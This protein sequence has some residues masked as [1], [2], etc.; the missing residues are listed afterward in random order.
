MNF[1]CCTS[2]YI[3]FF[4]VGLSYP[5][6]TFALT[7]FFPLKA[8]NLFIHSNIEPY[9][10]L[11]RYAFILDGKCNSKVL[12]LFIFFLDVKIYSFITLTNFWKTFSKNSVKYHKK[13]YS[14][15]FHVLQEKITVVWYSLGSLI[16]ER[17]F[18]NRYEKIIYSPW[19]K[20][21]RLPQVLLSK[22]KMIFAE[23]ET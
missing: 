10:S 21:I 1:W 5:P 23:K 2:M 3:L 12:N 9:V 11:G 16:E 14:F 20:E 7:A 22:K 6:Y 8:N 13:F 15:I 17:E 4:K 19:K 18:W